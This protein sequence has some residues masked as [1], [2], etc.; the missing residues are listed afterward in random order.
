MIRWL[1]KLF[2]PHSENDHQPHFWKTGPIVGLLAVILILEL[3]VLAKPFLIFNRDSFLGAV[4]PSVLVSLTNDER[5]INNASQLTVDPLLTKA[6]NLKAQDMA[7]KGYF[8]H[9]TPEGY[10]PWYWLDKVGYSYS[11]A[12]EN[13]AVNFTDSKDVV[14]AWMASPGHRANIV[15]PVYTQ[16]GIATAEG[17]YEGKSTVFV[18]QFFGTPVSGTLVVATTTNSAHFLASSTPNEIPS[19]ILKTSNVATNTPQVKGAES[20]VKSVAK[21]STLDTLVASP[22]HASE[23]VLLILLALVFV[24]LLL[25][26]LVKIKV[27]H[28]RII[29]LGVALILLIVGLII[30][31]DETLRDGVKI[32]DTGTSS[33][34]GI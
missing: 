18:V 7:A 19:K 29:I 6:A 34:L 13:L 33:F 20:D 10:S 16:I 1:K 28:P 4:L 14:D 21:P 2:I 30:F 27:Q 15:K 11:H 3:G 31:N 26:V 17:T 8:S 23:Y 32:G 12:G 5:N 25:A 22:R 9:T 24:A